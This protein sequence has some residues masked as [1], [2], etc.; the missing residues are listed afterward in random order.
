LKIVSRYLQF[1]NLQVI[2]P[3]TG[4]I[5]TRLKDLK[6]DIRDKIDECEDFEDNP[7]SFDAAAFNSIQQLAEKCST[8]C[9]AIFQDL[10][11][12]LTQTT[13][14]N[15]SQE[16]KPRDD[17]T[18][19]N[20]MRQRPP[21]QRKAVP[22]PSRPSL[23]TPTLPLQIEDPSSSTNAP[24]IEPAKPKSP[25]NIDSPSQFDLGPTLSGS[26]G[27]STRRPASREISPSALPEGQPRLIPKEIVHFRLSAN[28][29]F[30]ERRRQS[31]IMFQKEIR[32][33]ISSI[34]EHRVSEVFPESPLITSPL[35]GTAVSPIDGRGSRV[36]LSGYDTLMT[37]QRSLGQNSQDNRSSRTSSLLQ[38]R[39]VVSQ[40]QDSQDSI[41]GLRSA[42]PLSPPLSDHRHSGGDEN[43]GDL[44]TT[45]KVPGFGEGVEDGLHLVTNIDYDNEKIFVRQDGPSFSQPTPTTSMKSID[46]P[47]RHDTSFY[48]FGGFCEGAKA[49]LRGETGFKVVKRPSVCSFFPF[50]S[51][52]IDNK[53]RGIIVPQFQ[54]NV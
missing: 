41:F 7:D 21:S 40:R 53:S 34:E 51:S 4:L 24:P 36:S 5:Q 23:P 8:E 13:I 14:Q 49:L 38:D 10:R 43:L 39:P 33:S 6:N 22:R 50:I 46:Y 52:H 27:T 44:A 17:R 18:L 15:F 19:L 30:L 16:A 42:A 28:D 9:I 3:V 54:Q 29:E 47:I 32:K 12:Q 11:S 2:T 1:L 48:K 25:W 20:S 45:L 35:S 37:R 26:F 31:R